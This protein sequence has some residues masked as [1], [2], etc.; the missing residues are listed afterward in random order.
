MQCKIICGSRV[1]ATINS[2][3]PCS[4]TGE[5]TQAGQGNAEQGGKGS[6]SPSAAPSQA[7]QGSS[8]AL[9]LHWPT[10]TA[11]L[12][13]AAGLGPQGSKT[14]LLLLLQY[15]KVA[16]SPQLSRLRQDKLNSAQIV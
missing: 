4:A 11:W 3:Q 10:S 15:L 14:L 9:C 1:L 6:L 5:R 13:P 16:L 8:L 7:Q 2:Y 12:S